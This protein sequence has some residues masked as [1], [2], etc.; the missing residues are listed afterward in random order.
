MSFDR[1]GL[2]HPGRP[3]NEPDI[4]ELFEEEGVEL[5]EDGDLDGLDHP[6]AK[7]AGPQPYVPRHPA[8][9]EPPSAEN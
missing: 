3:G 1:P 8:H 6:G 2:P 5:D 4:D 9:E 7:S